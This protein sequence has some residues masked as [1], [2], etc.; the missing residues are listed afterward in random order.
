MS[1]RASIVLLLVGYLGWPATHAFAQQS[2]GGD[3][4]KWEIEVH[5]GG[6]RVGTPAEAKTAMPGP[7]ESFT[8][9]NGRP[10]RY[11][12]SW[13]FGD[14]AALANQWA[15]AFTILPRTQRITPLDPVVT[16]SAARFSNTGG[17]GFRV[18]RRLTPR[19]TAELNVDYN[20]STLKL[21][22]GA[23]SDVEASRSTFASLWNEQLTIDGTWLSPVV[24]SSS[25]IDE[26]SGGQIV[27]TG[28][29]TMRLRRRGVV[30]P[31]VTGGLGGLFNHGRAPS[32]AL[33]G[34]YAM[35]RI[36]QGG[37]VP[38]GTVVTF[39]QVDTVTM[40][41]V[42][43]DRALVGVVGGGFTYDLS[44]R[45]GLR[46]DLRLHL[47][48]NAVDTEVS[49]APSATTGAPG[50]VMTIG[51]ATTPTVVFSN[52]GSGATLSGPAITAFRTREGSGVQID[53]ALT[54]GYFWRF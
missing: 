45:H 44:R 19:F 51:S 35:T 18:G 39:N 12:S 5:A 29:V 16:G 1:I 46:V 27:A 53:T 38:V 20:P 36:G 42:R 8:A 24:S 37:Q 52:T 26:G 17:F 4:G 22:D 40:R 10:S 47:R 2:A 11:V 3:A 50:T 43:P 28:V 9:A 25:E 48:P 49:A 32:V 7:G 30:V 34:N 21:S 41:F 14:G 15:A 6:V 13:Y 54:V 31:Y 23:L 33:K